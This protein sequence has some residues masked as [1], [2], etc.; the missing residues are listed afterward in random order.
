MNVGDLQLQI[1]LGRATEAPRGG[2]RIAR[3][4]DFADERRQITAETRRRREKQR[5]AERSREKQREA[6]RS[7][8]K[9]REAERR[10]GLFHSP[11]RRKGERDVATRHSNAE[12]EPS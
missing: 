12:D 4:A 11:L 7:R 1:R 6:E 9:Q 8:E 10:L 5:E 3:D 2:E